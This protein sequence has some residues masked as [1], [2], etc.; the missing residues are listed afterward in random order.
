MYDYADIRT[1]LTVNDDD[2][3]VVI[4]VTIDPQT[5]QVWVDIVR[6]D[7]A[8]VALIDPVFGVAEEWVEKRAEYILR[9]DI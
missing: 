3:E 8:Q 6:R 9:G 2:I 7:G 1:V 5:E 4:E